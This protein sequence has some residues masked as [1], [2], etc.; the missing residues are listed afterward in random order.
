MAY[1]HEKAKRK[2]VHY[3]NGK[4]YINAK[5]ISNVRTKGV[6]RSKARNEDEEIIIYY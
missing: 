4:W 2:D 5:Q 1:K 3:K 6:I